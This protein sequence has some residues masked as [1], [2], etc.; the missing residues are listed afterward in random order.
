MKYRKLGNSGLKVSEISLGS[1]LTYGNSTDGKTTFEIVDAAMNAGINFFDTANVYSKGAAEVL[2]GE[3][4]RRYPRESYVLATK[5]WNRMGDFPNGSGLSRKH[6]FWQIDESLKRTGL[7]YIDLYYCHNFDTETP[8][9]ETMRA[10]DDLIRAGKILYIG[11]SNWNSTQIAEAI[12]A[13]DRYLL[14]RIIASQPMYN[15][16]NRNI[17][18]ELLP[19]CEANGISQAVYCPLA[20]GILTG[21]YKKGREIPKDS[22]AADPKSNDF[23]SRLLNDDTLEKTEKLE[24]VAEKLGIKLSHLALAWILRQSGVASCIVGATKVTQLAENI[25]ASDVL[26]DAKT[27]DEI[28][29]V[30]DN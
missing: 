2:V 21:K 7:D 27:L 29:Q 4:L 19:F 22:R 28:S 30:L 17:E 15:M 9:E 13:A 26:L 18:S 20:Q 8:I 14:D 6:I 16:L 1:W 12:R 25:A 23:I 11:V 5:V 24:S 3:A 10:F